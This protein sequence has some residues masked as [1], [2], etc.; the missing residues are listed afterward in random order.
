MA[1]LL[2]R[3]KGNQMQ[4]WMETRLHTYMYMNGAND[5]KGRCTSN[6]NRTIVVLSGGWII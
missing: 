3:I 5:S 2:S 4:N 1:H 6:P